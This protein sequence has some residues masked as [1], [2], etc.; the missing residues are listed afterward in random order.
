MASR[1]ELQ[2]KLEELLESEHVYYDPPESIKLEYPAIVYS[3]SKIDTKR[4]DDTA[5]LFR[6]SYELTVISRRPDTPVVM[7]LLA[8]PY[9]SYDRAYESDNLH[10]EVLTLYY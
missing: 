9:C 4:A 10:H 6:T 1:Q 2:S 3:K 7:R 8:L 5:Y